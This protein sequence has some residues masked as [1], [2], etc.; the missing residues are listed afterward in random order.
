MVEWMTSPYETFLLAER[1]KMPRQTDGQET[2]RR[3]E[4]AGRVG[5][6]RGNAAT[7]GRPARRC[8]ERSFGMQLPARS[9]YPNSGRRIAY[10]QHVS[11]NETVAKISLSPTA[12]H[13]SSEIFSG[14][15]GASPP[16]KTRG[17]RCRLRQPSRNTFSKERRKNQRI[18]PIVPPALR[19]ERSVSGT[20]RSRTQPP[21]PPSRS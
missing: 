19:A 6:R 12:R 4:S 1:N 9:K 14:V 21:A 18:K 2:N 7:N 15:K 3:K 11:Y 17:I 5:F 10:H 20:G 13:C 8:L 16:P